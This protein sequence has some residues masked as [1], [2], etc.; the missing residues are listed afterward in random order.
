MM[1]TRSGTASHGLVYSAFSLCMILHICGMAGC[2]APQGAAESA[3]TSHSIQQHIDERRARMKLK[4]IKPD[5]PAPEAPAEQSPAL[6]ESSQRRLARSRDRYRDRRFTEATLELEKA[7][8][9]DPNHPLLHRELALAHRAAG[10]DERVRTHVRKALSANADDIVLHYLL[11]SL[12][13]ADQQ[14]AQAI[15]HFRVGLKASNASTTPVFSALSHFQLAKVLNA[16]G[17]LSA[18]IGQYDQ[19]E[20]DVADLDAAAIVDPELG[21][22]LQVNGGDA[23]AEKS[24]LYEKLGMLTEA[25][26]ALS[27][28]FTDRK[29]TPESRERLATLLIR[30]GRYDEAIKH[31]R[32]LTD[33]PFR[34]T[35]LLREIRTRA[36]HPSAVIEDVAAL[37]QENETADWLVCFVDVLIEFNQSDDAERILRQGL[38]D[39]PGDV[40]LCW[41][42]MDLYASRQAWSS[43]LD[44]ATAAIRADVESRAAIQEKIAT[45][46]SNKEAVTAL[47]GTH[48]RHAASE[49]DF[50]TAYVLGTLAQAANRSELAE[51]LY[52]NA[53]EKNPAFPHASLRLATMLIKRY[54]WQSAIDVLTGMSDS[55]RQQSETQQL[56]GDAFAG[57]DKFDTAVEHYKEAIRL[58]RANVAAMVALADTYRQS[59]EDLR[60]QRQYEAVL[61]VNSLHEYSREALLEI[62]LQREDVAAASSQL[63]ELKRRSADPHR[64]ARATALIELANGTQPANEDKYRETLLAAVETLGPNSVT[65]DRIGRSFLRQDRT[66]EALVYARKSADTD[67]ANLDAL[68]LEFKV[69]DRLLDYPNAIATLRSL[70]AVHPNRVAWKINLWRTLTIDQQFDEA[71]HLA[72]S[73]LDES[74]PDADELTDEQRQIYRERALYTLQRAKRYDEQIKLLRKWSADDNVTNVMT[75]RLMFT[76]QQAGQYEEALKIARERYDAS[77]SDKVAVTDLFDVLREQKRHVEAQQLML[78]M[79]EVDPENMAWHARLV[80]LLVNSGSPDDALELVDN[81][82]PMLENPGI[83]QELRIQV[84][85][86]AQRYDD[87]IE[88]ALDWETGDERSTTE[89]RRRLTHRMRLAQLYL[90]A[91]KYHEAVINLR[92]WS[93]ETDDPRVKFG[94]LQILATCYQFQDQTDD[95]LKAMQKAFDLRQYSDRQQAV[96]INN[97]FGYMLTDE[98]IRLEEAERMIRFALH[99]SPENGAYLDS[100]GWVEYKKGEFEQAVRWLQKAANSL[101]DDDPVVFDHLGDAL[102][103]LDQRTEA[104]RVWKQ[105]LEIAN[106]NLQE[107]QRGDLRRLIEALGEKLNAIETGETPDIAPIGEAVDGTASHENPTAP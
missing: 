53:A 92:R 56:L 3:S 46:A 87:A 9:R 34:A 80:D 48:E 32:L 70:L 50:A 45:L 69:Y 83:V 71:Y 82:A 38:S 107:E 64:I 89:T 31:A 28:A 78:T 21:V 47:L 95:A 104:K 62:N 10:N 63:V 18:A 44:V 79:L 25:A 24:V 4:E 100:M 11:G 103:Q 6:S 51:A 12:A 72:M 102:W 2:T 23:R 58:D 73:E 97:D 52:R 8:R 40:R 30:I 76:Y 101:E 14:N 60:A 17:Y 7:L 29:P 36:G 39:Q 94:F 15:Q 20:A 74:R 49:E 88:L 93:D 27:G 84:L 65:L 77:P 96:G 54:A 1:K 5:P 81:I 59:G 13:A 68:E 98:G 86:D 37:Y 16:E 33:D 90:L 85:R 66:R 42:L 22:L 35:Q 41:K 61:E 26:D 57:L 106:E 75:R 43:V 55:E 67:P 19:Y 91:E 99:Q 105:S